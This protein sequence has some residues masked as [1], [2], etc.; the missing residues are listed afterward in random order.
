MRHKPGASKTFNNGQYTLKMLRKQKLL[1]ALVGVEAKNL[2]LEDLKQHIKRL[3]PIGNIDVV[4]LPQTIVEGSYDHFRMQHNSTKVLTNLRI[5]LKDASADKILGITGFDLFANN[6]N[7]VF[8]EAELSGRFGVVSIYR[9]RAG[10]VSDEVF[11]S[12]LRKECV[13]E[14][15]HMFGLRHCVSGRCVMRFSNSIIEVD[16][17][18][19]ILCNSCRSEL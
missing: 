19:D 4:E 10:L 9:L 8:G 5:A 15:G 14:L 6:L 12:R 11:M 3:Y 16:E 1:L 17:K 7:F 2:P 13:H 18:S